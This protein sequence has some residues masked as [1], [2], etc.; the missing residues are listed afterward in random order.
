M[1]SQTEE[2]HGEPTVNAVLIVNS[3]P[4]H[5]YTINDTTETIVGANVQR[6]VKK[7][8]LILAE[9]PVSSSMRQGSST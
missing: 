4:L 6:S 5:T 3:F 8:E 1:S 2:A 7:T 9:C